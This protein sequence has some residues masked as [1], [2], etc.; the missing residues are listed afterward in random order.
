MSRN[1][2]EFLTKTLDQ[3]REETE[4]AMLEDMLNWYGSKGWE[5]VHTVDVSQLSQGPR[6]EMQEP[7]VLFIFKRITVEKERQ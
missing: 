5:L 6:L 7:V 1:K 2:W 4:K 3:M